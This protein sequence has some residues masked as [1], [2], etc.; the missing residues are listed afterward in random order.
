MKP[1]LFALLSWSAAAAEVVEPVSVKT[2]ES[3]SVPTL[4]F[5]DDRVTVTPG[6]GLTVKTA[7]GNYAI[8][9]RARVQLRE[10]FSYDT[11]AANE[12]NVK[13]LRFY[14]QG[15]ALVPELKY[16][17]QL[18]FGTGDYENGNA[19]PIFDAFVEYTKLRDLNVRVG[20]Y[21]VPFDRGR[22]V[23]ESGL[24]FVDRQIA[25][26]EL[27]LDRDV[28]LMLSSSDLFG[29]KQWLAYNVFVGGGEGRNRVGSAVAAPL[30]VA[31]L[32][33]RPFGT[34]DDDA[35]GDLQRDARPR[36]SVGVAGAYN[37]RTNRAQSTF[38]AT[39][40]LGTF[41]YLHGAVDVVFKWHGF[42][43]LAEGVIRKAT[44]DVLEGASAAGATVREYSR[45]GW[46][47]FVQAGLMVSKLVEVTARW[48]Q[49]YAL[50]GTD[51][52]LISLAA[53]QG[54]QLGAGTNVYLNGHAFKLQADYFYIWGPASTTGRH[55]ARLVLDA[56]F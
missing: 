9:L 21:F 29:L 44:N 2:D 34:F 32:A 56:S 26:R 52:S 12:I 40:T 46:G 45:S 37:A 36:L 41:D 10:T 3:V 28:G 15:N 38:G 53:T 6:R 39:Y 50:A 47:Y 17:V 13:T 11:V 5:F 18:A 4:T 54:R 51:P 16:L 30:V 33:V 48:D 24:Q 31:R 49:L 43:L 19:S 22:T 27:T 7:D 25:V 8:T 14:V 1:L 23:R 20:Q 55:V 42:S 35:E